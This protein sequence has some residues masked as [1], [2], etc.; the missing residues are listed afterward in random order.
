MEK[1][2][3]TNGGKMVEI[4][5]FLLCVDKQ[6]NHLYVLHRDFPACLIYVEPE[7]MRR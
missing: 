1:Q 4:T 6:N 3:I 7:S 5:R 2:F